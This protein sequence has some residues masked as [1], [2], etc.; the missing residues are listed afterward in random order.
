MKNEP[1]LAEVMTLLAEQI[2]ENLPN[3]REVILRSSKEMLIKSGQDL[4]RWNAMLAAGTIS[5]QEYEW[6]VDSRISVVE[7]DGLKTAGLALAR[8][9]ELKASIVQSITGAALRVGGV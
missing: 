6:L 7:M 3:I 2:R 9:D 5:A 1:F 8:I 4:A